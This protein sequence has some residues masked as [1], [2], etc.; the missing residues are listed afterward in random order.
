[1]RQRRGSHHAKGRVSAACGVGDT[2]AASLQRGRTPASTE[3]RLHHTGW[4]LLSICMA[5]GTHPRP[6]K[7]A[8]CP[9]TA[10]QLAD[11]QTAPV[12]APHS[13]GGDSGPLLLSSGRAVG[14]ACGAP[15]CSCGRACTSGCCG[16]GGA[17]AAEAF[18][19]T[20]HTARSCAGMGG[21]S[22]SSN[23]ARATAAGRPCDAP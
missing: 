6:S 14:Q 3:H 16:W 1:M 13:P 21:F 22:C 11:G 5:L 17:A 4:P 9:L 20:A 10:Q 7:H 8:N 12:R 23:P 19:G 2:A 15:G 18:T